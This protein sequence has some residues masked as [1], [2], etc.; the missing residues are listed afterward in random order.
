MV[1]GAAAVTTGLLGEGGSLALIV[2]AGMGVLGIYW[3][4]QPI[5]SGSGRRAGTTAPVRERDAFPGRVTFTPRARQNGTQ[6][7]LA[8]PH[9]D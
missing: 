3:T 9:W 4:L 5:S 2:G 6:A 7:D 8:L 1:L